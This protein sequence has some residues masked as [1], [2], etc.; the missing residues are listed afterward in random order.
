[1]FDVNGK[2]FFGALRDAAELQLGGEHSCVEVFALAAKTGEMFEVQ[3]AQET[4]A[5]LPA[6]VTALLMEA[7]HKAMREDPAALLDA[8]NGQGDPHKPM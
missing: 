8:W 2:R 1:M 7:V 5:A 4:L 6:D 3:A